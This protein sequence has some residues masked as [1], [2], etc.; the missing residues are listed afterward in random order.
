MQLIIAFLFG[1][2][3][4]A[5]LFLVQLLPEPAF[6]IARF[7]YLMISLFL[8]SIGLLSYF[9]SKLPL[10]PYDALTHVI[11]DRFKLEFGKAKITSDL[12]NVGIAGG[13][14]LVFIQALGSI[15]IGTLI[16]AYLVGKILG[17]EIARY[18]LSLN[19]WIYKNNHSVPTNV[20]TQYK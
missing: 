12:I 5:S 19:N 10:M 17:W 13:L 7:G 1:F 11:S 20:R 8:V 3:M 6:V 15:G 9:T 18:Q 2:F 4:E 14:C 16:T